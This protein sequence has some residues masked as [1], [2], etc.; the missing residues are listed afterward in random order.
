M[1]TDTGTSLPRRHC[2]V[3]YA[4][5]PVGETRV[6]REAE[7]L[8]AAGWEVDVISLRVAGEPP[9]ERVHGV[10]VHRL[11]IGHDKR[12][13]ARQ[14]ASYVR[15]T[16][17]AAARLT[18][19]HRFRR[20]AT[21]Q[22]HNL[23][24]F[25]VFAALVPKLA[26]VPVILDL[27][28]LMPEFFAGRFGPGGAPWLLR[29]VRWQERLACRFADHVITVSEHWRGAL[30]ERGVRADRCSVVMNVADE[31][32]FVPSGAARERDGTRLLYHG[33]MTRRYGLDLAVEAVAMVREEIP[34]I[35]LVLLGRGDDV[36]AL[37]ALVA[38]LGVEDQ[39]ERLRDHIPTEDLPALI[40]SADV[41]LAPYRDDVFTDG[42]VP[43]KLMEYAAMGLPCIAAR[44]AAIAAFFG[45]ANVEFFAPGDAADLARCIR[46]LHAD[47][48]RRAAL[49]ERSSAFTDA[50]NWRTEGP[51]Y[52][53]L[54]ERL[55]SRASR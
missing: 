35:H 16:A 46:L 29:L 5:Y 34:G 1:G 2:M 37:D 15:F 30:L 4:K 21:I 47:P 12:S 31:R 28:D 49:A 32:V 50:H 42:I 43:T 38:R 53:A 19:L 25:L 7:A 13:L 9:R 23:P 54:V 45:D 24:D 48:A 17:L 8:V 22:I 14:F 20:Y 55:A 10:D 41:G 51:A 26:G 33:T 11:P 36:E 18:R 3:V 39:V 44:T 52:V 27:H 40:E 6:Q